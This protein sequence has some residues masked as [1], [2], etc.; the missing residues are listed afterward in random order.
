[1]HQIVKIPSKTNGFLGLAQ[2]V[3][4]AASVWDEQLSDPRR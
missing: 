2:N 3:N 4:Y 1:M